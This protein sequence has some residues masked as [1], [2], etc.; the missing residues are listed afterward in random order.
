MSRAVLFDVD[1][2]LVHGYHSRP[3]QQKRWDENLLEDLGIDPERFQAEF[4]WDVFVKKVIPGKMGLVE[5]LD[6]VLPGLGYRGPTNRIV[7]YWLEHDSALDVHLVELVRQLKSAGTRLY[8]ATNQEHLRA[9]WLWQSLR[10]GELF[11]DIFYAARLG[12]AKPNAGFFAEVER[13]L[14]PQAEPPLFFDDSPKVIIAA[15]QAG[16][17]AIEYHDIADCRDHPWIGEHLQKS[18]G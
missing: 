13:R 8:L 5:A 15:R 9:Q 6:R 2:V 7:A 14:G 1:G 18:I 3:E 11:D 17:E 16:W 12:I 4:I 10:L